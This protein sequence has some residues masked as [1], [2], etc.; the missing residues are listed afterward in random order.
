[1]TIKCL[2]IHIRDL[3]DHDNTTLNMCRQK[4]SDSEI[5]RVFFMN[6]EQI[7]KILEESF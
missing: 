2:F 1:M 5:K 6:K 7:N 3:R 4:Y